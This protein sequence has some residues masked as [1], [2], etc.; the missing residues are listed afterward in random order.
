MV[1]GGFD[2]QVELNIDWNHLLDNLPDDLNFDF[3]DLP[4]ADGLSTS[5]NSTCSLSIDDIEQYLMDDDGLNQ[6]NENDQTIID[7][8]LFK[9]FL[10]DLSPG[11]GSASDRSKDSSASPQSA[12]EVET[13]EEDREKEKPHKSGEDVLQMKESRAVDVVDHDDDD[14]DKDPLAKK[15]KR[16][17]RNRDAAVRSRERK[18]MYVRDLELKSKYYEAECKRL[19]ILLQC[20]LSENQALRLSLHNTKAFDASMSKQESAV[21]LLE[22][23]LLGSLLGLLGIIYLLLILPSHLL[24]TLE[25]VLLENEG[26]AE[27]ENVAP[28]RRAENKVRRVTIL[29]SF[30]LSKRCKASRSRMKLSYAVHSCGFWDE[31]LCNGVS[32]ASSSWV[33][34]PT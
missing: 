26:S 16:K 14:G 31:S 8:G 27:W 1:D 18:K 34:T 19:G 22:S 15:L 17:M 10:L 3:C 13:D 20:C 29:D 9:D 4:V 28:P 32:I 5:L 24:S 25:A 11:S 7:D 12:V 2:D 30:M 6:S 21:L 23:L 33:T